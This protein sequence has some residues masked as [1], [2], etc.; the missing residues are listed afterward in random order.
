ML[1]LVFQE[2]YFPFLTLAGFFSFILFSVFLLS[3]LVTSDSDEVDAVGVVFLGK[4]HREDTSR[5]SCPVGIPDMLPLVDV[6]ASHIVGVVVPSF[7]IHFLL[8]A[9]DDLLA[10]I[11]LGDIR[12][13]GVHVCHHDALPAGVFLSS[14]SR[15]LSQKVV[16]SLRVT[17]VLH[18][19]AP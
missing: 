19:I 4:R 18:H 8:S 3:F 7:Q 12:T 15:Q 1:R 17:G 11:F 6:S 16:D 5:I 2:I 9:D 10:R 13:F 14:L